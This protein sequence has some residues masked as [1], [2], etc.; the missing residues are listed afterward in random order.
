MSNLI[1]GE[2]VECLTASFEVASFELLDFA[3]GID[4]KGNGASV[5]TIFDENE[6][7]ARSCNDLSFQ[8]YKER[9]AVRG[10]TRRNAAYAKNETKLH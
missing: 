7:L 6:A 10:K 9:Q 8:A 2:V 3:V 4:A 5:A 1:R